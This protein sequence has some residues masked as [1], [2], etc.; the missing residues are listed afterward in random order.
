MKA[1][2]AVLIFILI[3]YGAVASAYT[4]PN[5]GLCEYTPKY[6]QVTFSNI[7]LFNGYCGIDGECYIATTTDPNNPINRAY[8]LE[9]V[10]PNEIDP[11]CKW[12]YA[13][14]DPN[15]IS[16]RRPGYIS[17]CDSATGLEIRVYYHDNNLYVMADNLGG[18]QFGY[19]I[20]FDAVGSVQSGCVANLGIANTIST[21]SCSVEWYV[22]PWTAGLVGTVEIRELP[23]NFVDFAQFANDWLDG[24]ADFKD[25]RDFLTEWLKPLQSI[26]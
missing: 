5:C 18:S 3:F 26:Q 2:K 13:D 7:A 16:A 1:K 23:K 24:N 9:W 8:I 15:I 25:L 11:W 20:Y 10:E 21:C 12:R 22:P 4:D 17:D 19:A 6:I 14:P